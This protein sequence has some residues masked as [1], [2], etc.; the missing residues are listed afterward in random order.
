[1]TEE[2]KHSKYII[3]PLGKKHNKAEFNCGVHA[4]DNYLQIQAS[5]DMKKKVAVTH[6]LTLE[7]SVQ[8]LGYYTLS[9]I[10][11]VPGE[12][13]IEVA[14]KL[15]R[16]PTLPGVLLGRLA[17]DENFKKAGIGSYLLIDAIKQILNV[18]N[19][20]GNVAAI[21]DAKNENAISF[22]KSFGFIEFPDNNRRL[23]LLLSTIRK[24]S[25]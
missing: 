3:E 10:G 11:I 4:L 24:L 1:M 21:V 18:S 23:F 6:V 22:Y 16:Y 5:Q 9:S 17:R 2:K 8:V 15:P 19:T 12:L 13:P 14:R 25:L 7:N 20:I